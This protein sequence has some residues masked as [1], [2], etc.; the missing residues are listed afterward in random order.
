MWL[1]DG[2]QIVFHSRRT[3]NLD[4]FVINA[5]GTG[6][7][8]LT[9]TPT[10]EFFPVWSPDGTQ[11]TFTGNTLDPSNFDVYVMNADGSGITRLTFNEP[12]VFD[13]RC[14]WGVLTPFSKDECK[15]RGWQRFNSANF[16]R[17]RNQ[18]QCVSFVNESQRNRL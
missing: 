14:A 10:H 9:S 7:R 2:S 3:G 18:G 11:I 16:E 5:D 17:F 1:P 12:G 6:V 8:Q 13:G 4:I 15:R